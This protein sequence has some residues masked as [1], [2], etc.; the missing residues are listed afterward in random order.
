MGF[1]SRQQIL[2]HTVILQGFPRDQSRITRDLGK[3]RRKWGR[4]EVVQNVV[5]AK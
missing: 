5:T 4:R 1:Y 2:I 3:E